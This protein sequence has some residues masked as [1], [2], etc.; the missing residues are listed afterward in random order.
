MRAWITGVLTAL[1]IMSLPPLTSGAALLGLGGPILASGGRF[2]TDCAF[3]HRLPDDPIVKPALPGASHSHD[4]FG[5][6][7]TNAFSTYD[8][9]RAGSTTCDREQ[10]AAG[11]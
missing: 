9:L 6:A 3:S 4:F 11:Y 10:D 5:N 2:T 7:T 8:S 1:M